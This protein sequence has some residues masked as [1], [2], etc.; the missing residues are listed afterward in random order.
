LT[1]REAEVWLR[2]G[3]PK[4][5]HNA[6]TAK[7]LVFVTGGKFVRCSGGGSRP[8]NTQESGFEK[9]AP[10]NPKIIKGESRE[11]YKRSKKKNPEKLAP[12]FS[13]T[14]RLQARD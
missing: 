12:T 7:T 14:R 4:T 13:L 3:G 2:S 8:K 1:V 6:S 11:F 9:A 10:V 5:T